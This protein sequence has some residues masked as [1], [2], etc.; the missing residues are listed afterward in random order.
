MGSSLVLPE[1]NARLKKVMKTFSLGR[2]DMAHLWRSFQR[3][4]RQKVGKIRSFSIFDGP[5]IQKSV[6]C[7][8]LFSLLDIELEQDQDTLIGF[9]EFVHCIVALCC[10]EPK[11]MLRFCYYCYDPERNGHISIEDY[12]ALMNSLHGV[13]PPEKADGNLRESWMQLKFPANEKIEIE[14]VEGF[15][16]QAPLILQ[17]AFRFQQ[18][19]AEMYGG[20]SYWTRKKRRLMEDRIR[21]DRLLEKKRIKKEKKLLAKRD[22]K[23]KKSMGIL[24]YYMCPCLRFMY[25]PNDERG[26]T[27]AQKAALALQRRTEELAQKNPETPAWRALEKKIDP[28]RGGS[29]RYVGDKLAKTERP[30]EERAQGR[31]ERRAERKQDETLAHKFRTLGEDVDLLE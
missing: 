8:C 18:L 28:S 26:M 7:E 13:I 2:G 11:E 4:D 20:V 6:L 12:K 16:R 30:R 19:M 5:E 3:L 1:Q 24:R 15:H 31:A 27:E 9:P 21:A 10:F 29:E 25:D 17:P 23:V 22:N 14:D